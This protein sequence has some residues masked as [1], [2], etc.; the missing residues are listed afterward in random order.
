MKA[1]LVRVL[2]TTDSQVNIKARTHEKVCHPH[3]HP[4]CDTDDDQGSRC[5]LRSGGTLDDSLQSFS[6]YLCQNV[7]VG[8]NTSIQLEGGD[9][10]T[11]AC[12]MC[13]RKYAYT[14]TNTGRLDWRR[15]RAVL[16]RYSHHGEEVVKGYKALSF[17]VE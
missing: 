15:P 7:I 16:P 9:A 1:N 6:Q 8:C 10:L 13:V 17:Q 4:D 11:H 3:R 12:C 2:Q 5:A 14:R